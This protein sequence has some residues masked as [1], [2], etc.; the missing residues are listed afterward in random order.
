MIGYSYGAYLSASVALKAP[1]LVDR[2]VMIAPA[3]VFAPV[4]LSF[5]LR[6]LFHSL[7]YSGPSGFAFEN[8]LSATPGF[9]YA[10]DMQEMH[11]DFL[12]AGKRA[13]PHATVLLSQPHQFSKEE[14]EVVVSH[15]TLVIWGAQE[16]VF[17]ASVARKTANSVGGIVLKEYPGNGHLLIIEEA[18]PVA[19]KDTVD[20]I[21]QS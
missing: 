21:M 10:R 13:S 17:D 2:L 9:D 15:P 14:L 20:F 12:K 6:A 18:R 3:A 7:V 5:V 11:V 8:W 1:E 19:E 16:K 4:S